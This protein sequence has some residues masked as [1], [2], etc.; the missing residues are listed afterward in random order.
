LADGFSTFGG[1]T[2]ATVAQSKILPY[3][4]TSRQSHLVS[5]SL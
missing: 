3:A 2:A 1:V 4:M 5:P